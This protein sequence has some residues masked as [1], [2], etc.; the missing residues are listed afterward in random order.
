MRGVE[1]L[2]H[3]GRIAAAAQLLGEL[4]ERDQPRRGV[5]ERGATL[6]LQCLDGGLRLRERGRVG[7]RTRA[8]ASSPACAPFSLHRAGTLRGALL[9]RAARA[10]WIA[11]RFRDSTDMSAPQVFRSE[12]MKKARNGCC[13]RIFAISAAVDVAVSVGNDANG[14]FGTV[15]RLLT[16]A[17]APAATSTWLHDSAL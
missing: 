2:H 9:A 6:L 17:Y 5:G 8:A 11:A 14:L 3:V 12:P 7:R 15:T 16:L 4:G 1:R 10:L 13:S